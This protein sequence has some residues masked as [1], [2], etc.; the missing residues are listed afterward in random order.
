M[1]RRE[2]ITLIGGVAAW[3]F[4]AG[5]QQPTM[6]LIGF[7]QSG[8]AGATTH[9]LAAFHSGLREAGYIEGQNVAIVYGYADGRDGPDIK[10][11]QRFCGHKQKC[12]V[13]ENSL[14]LNAPSTQPIGTD[15]K[16]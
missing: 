3:P 13:A 16:Q 5:A 8:S 1:R 7:L 12:R 15:P 14:R 2:F 9:V 4:P 6:P 11:Q 10:D